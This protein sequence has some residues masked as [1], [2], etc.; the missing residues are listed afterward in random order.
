LL[1]GLALHRT[2]RRARHLRAELL[3]L[4]AMHPRP[5]ILLST[6]RLWRTLPY[7]QLHHAAMRKDGNNCKETVRINTQALAASR[8]DIFK[9]A[10]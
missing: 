7:P 4:F 10:S 2:A 1:S 8:T 9:L 5:A 6:A 3:P